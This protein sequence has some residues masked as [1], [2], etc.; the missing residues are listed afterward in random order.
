MKQS[1]MGPGEGDPGEK[2][3]YGGAGDNKMT[4]APNNPA[5]PVKSVKEAFMAAELAA[6]YESIKKPK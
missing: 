6:E 3:M 1:T 4:Q 2:N 5:R